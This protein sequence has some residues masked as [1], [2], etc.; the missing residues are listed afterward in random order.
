MQPESRA[1]MEAALA[2]PPR[3]P[4]FSLRIS[5]ARPFGSPKSSAKTIDG[6]LPRRR[7]QAFLD[8]NYGRPQWAKMVRGADLTSDVVVRLDLTTQYS[9]GGSWSRGAAAYWIPGLRGE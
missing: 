5:I 6:S 2:A 4:Y 7:P 3:T 9:R 1:D 8:E